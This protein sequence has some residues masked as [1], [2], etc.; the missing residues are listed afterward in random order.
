MGW[1]CSTNEGEE[2]IHGVISKKVV[3]YN[4]RCENLKSRHSILYD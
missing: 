1:A 4:H 2:E 3:L